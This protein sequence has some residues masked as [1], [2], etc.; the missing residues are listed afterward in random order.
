MSVFKLAIIEYKNVFWK[1]IFKVIGIGLVIF[2]T[3]IFVILGD[4]FSNYLKGEMRIIEEDF[5]TVAFAKKDDTLNYITI[6]ILK[7]DTINN[8]AEVEGVK[9]LSA[10]KNIYAEKIIHNE[11]EILRKLIFGV[12]DNYLD[13]MNIDLS[14]GRFPI[15]DNEIIVGGILSDKISIGEE[16]YISY[17][18]NEIAYK[19][20]G[21]MEKQEEQMFNT[22]PFMINNIIIMNEKNNIF[23]NVN[24][25]HCVGRLENIDD[26]ATTEMEIHEILTLDKELNNEVS[27]TGYLPTF[28]G[29]KDVN[30][31]INVW[32]GYIDVFILL[33]AII[34]SIVAVSNMISV[35]VLEALK[36]E[37]KFALFLC[38]G[39]SKV[40]VQ[41]YYCIQ[42]IISIIISIIF[43][44][45]MALSLSYLIC[46]L[47][48]WELIL[49]YSKIFKIIFLGMI[50]F[51]CV[52]YIVSM[53]FRKIF[54]G[55]VLTKEN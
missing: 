54:I 14:E 22:V 17:E 34:S 10:V 4:S 45:I 24:Y 23:S 55:K 2:L 29:E 39:S 38:V 47:V 43:T 44:T 53:K 41:K 52:T 48:M 27:N 16:L 11:E 51:I 32:F 42:N 6:P 15:S 25:S 8:I 7:D 35:S 3:L 26:Y 37:K 13:L 33:I 5:F 30:K 50:F 31:L 1:N 19:V 46:N 18:G 49:D 9:N 36:E 40:Q 20:T 21:L 12:N 28:I